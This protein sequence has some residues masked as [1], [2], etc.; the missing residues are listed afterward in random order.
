MSRGDMKKVDIFIFLKKGNFNRPNHMEILKP[1][2][3]SVKQLRQHW[4]GD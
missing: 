3:K 4:Q 2:S 1:A